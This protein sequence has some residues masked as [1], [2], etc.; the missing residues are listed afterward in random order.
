MFLSHFEIYILHSSYIPHYPVS[1]GNILLLLMSS[2]IDRP[3]WMIQVDAKIE[4][5]KF[6]NN[7]YINI[8]KDFHH[9]I[10]YWQIFHGYYALYY[11]LFQLKILLWM[12]KEW[13]CHVQNFY[14]CSDDQGQN[15]ICTISLLQIRMNVLCITSYFP[16][17]QHFTG[18]MAYTSERMCYESHLTFQQINIPHGIYTPHTI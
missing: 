6:F 2:H 9:D 4:V 14:H 13:C 16:T 12:L 5:S 18:Y 8:L 11:G 10:M 3:S 17:D 7:T 1:N 15:G